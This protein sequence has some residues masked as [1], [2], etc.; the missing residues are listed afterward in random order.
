MPVA[1]FLPPFYALIVPIAT[2]VADPVA[3]PARPSHRRV[4]TAA[5]VGL[6]YG[7]ASVVFHGLSGLAAPPGGTLG[8]STVWT[9]L[10]VFSA[11]VQWVL[12]NAMVVTA[13]KGSNRTANIRAAFF[14]GE[15]IY[16]DI[17]EI[18][19]AVLVTFGVAG[20]P[21]L[22]LAALPVVGRSSGR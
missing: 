8:H 20:N 1:I 4:F 15:A 11:V 22:A 13:I 2:G 18:C 17:A 5:A 10:V 19:A 3:G 14:N 7:A 16:N 12:N 9:L 21:L 6:S